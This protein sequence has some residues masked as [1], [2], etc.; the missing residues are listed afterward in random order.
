ML[1]SATKGL[2]DF[3]KN[4]LKAAGAAIG[5]TVGQAIAEIIIQIGEFIWGIF[6]GHEKDKIKKI[7][8]KRDKDLEEFEKQSEI[9]LSRLEEIYDA[10]IEMRKEKLSE[11]DDEYNKEIE[12][13]KQAQSKG[14]I[15][16]EKFQKRLSDVQTEYKT[17]K[18]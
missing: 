15:S 3:G 16:G 13:L 11:L 6:K 17:K 12:F 14:Q 10:E 2:V 8:E 4:A 5:G 18:A 1:Y 7:E 9:A